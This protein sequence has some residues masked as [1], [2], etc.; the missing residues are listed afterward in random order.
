MNP[1]PIYHLAITSNPPSFETVLAILNKAGHGRCVTTL[2][3]KNISI[4]LWVISKLKGERKV[5]IEQLRNSTGIHDVHLAAISNPIT[6]EEL[7]AVREVF[8]ELNWDDSDLTSEKLADYLQS[9][10]LHKYNLYLDCKIRN[11]KVKLSINRL[12]D[13]N[14]F[15]TEWLTPAPDHLMYLPDKELTLNDF[16]V[17]EEVLSRSGEAPLPPGPTE[18]K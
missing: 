10:S 6:M 4:E 13:H 2:I 1:K 5:V 17:V 14:D 15:S 18:E 11:D 12:E 9:L 3:H 7:T 8:R 16:I